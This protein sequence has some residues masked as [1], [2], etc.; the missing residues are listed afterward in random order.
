MQD[1]TTTI[2]ARTEERIKLDRA[3]QQMTAAF[4][5]KAPGALEFADEYVRRQGIYEATLKNTGRRV[6]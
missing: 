5:A 2:E 4:A 3:R 1:T 6:Y